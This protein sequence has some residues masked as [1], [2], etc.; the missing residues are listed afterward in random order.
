[1]INL[2]N[3]PVNGQL[4]RDMT[5]SLAHRGPDDE[6][7]WTDRNVGF[8]HRRLSIIDLSASGHQPMPNEDESIWIVS[9]GEIYNFPELRSDL[10]KKGHCFR[11]G[12]DTETIIHLYEDHGVDCLQF[13]RGMFAFA[14]WD[15][16]NETLFLARDRA[17]KKPLYYSH[18]KDRFV[19]ASE[20][21]AILRD[22]SFCA[23]PD[24]LAVHHYLTYMSVPSPLSAFKGIN[25]L[26][27]AHYLLMKNGRAEVKRYWKLSYLPKHGGD[28]R[29]LAEEL[30]ARVR[31]AVKLRLMSDVPL[32]AF[33]S[34][35]MD[36][37][38]IIAVMS[39]L[40]SEPVKTFSIGFD[41]SDY[42][43]LPY[44]E[45]VAK[46]FGTDH[47][48]YT[49]RPDAVEVLPQ[50]VAHY[51]E[52]FADPSAIPSHYV[53]QLARQKVTVALNGDGGDEIF[54]GYER[55]AANELAERLETFPGL[56][57]KRLLPAVVS[58]F[59]TAGRSDSFFWKLRRFSEALPL[60]PEMRNANW[61]THFKND[62][63]GSLYSPVF[64]E[65]VLGSDSYRIIMEMYA[66]AD[67]DNFFDR[68]LYAD[69]ALYLA[70]TLLVKMDR[71]SMAHGLEVR[72]P[73][74]DHELMDFAAKLP[75][76]M[77]V[78]KGKTKILLK[79]AFRQKLPPE[80]TA[81]KKMGFGVPLE[82]W[83]RNELREIVFDMLLSRR[84]LERGY[85]QRGFIE[86][87]LSQHTARQWNWQFQIYNL[88]MLELWHRMFIDG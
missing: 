66:A 19:F 6:G 2:D 37:S 7:V 80:I 35:G 27:A 36:S 58:L 39:E 12:T 3:A 4:L 57:I 64:S 71:A 8:G 49:V 61:I 55:Y 82:H 20:P 86:K 47:T 69:V 21:K 11:S 54:G 26:P 73:F 5:A 33:L 22:R 87:M 53:S 74:L 81:R 1:M 41:E 65:T 29:E 16:R 10:L 15:S 42:N 44:A 85:F 38:V 77:K 45:L 13:L 84:S 28:E 50:I 78:H 68:M 67:A 62:M 48:V 43:E 70:D 34:G 63:K 30:V 88:L 46:R 59:P 75:P 18:T 60:S 79:K 83:F 14:L 17:G 24:P 32:G 72:C 31:E 25:K 40:M 51:Q 56:L 23:E 76:R 9:N 52:P